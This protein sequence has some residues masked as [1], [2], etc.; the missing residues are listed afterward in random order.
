MQRKE[1]IIKNKTEGSFLPQRIEQEYEFIFEDTDVIVGGSVLLVVREKI[2]KGCTITIEGDSSVEI[3]GTVADNVQ[4][5]MRG[6][7]KLSFEKRPPESVIANIKRSNLTEQKVSIPPLD[8]E[9]SNE[10]SGGSQSQGIPK[11]ATSSVALMNQLIPGL[12]VGGKITVGKVKVTQINAEKGCVTSLGEGRYLIQP[13]GHPHTLLDAHN[14]PQP[15]NPLVQ[16]RIDGIAHEGQEILV[17]KNK[18]FVDGIIQDEDG[19]KS[20]QP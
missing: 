11:P 9:S 3:D 7:S 8:K 15:K 10:L 16:A 1:L 6:T 14:K 18:V 5:I 12:F 13:G 2:E 4:F 19:N 20:Y 17:D